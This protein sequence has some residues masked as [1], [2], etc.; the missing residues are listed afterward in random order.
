MILL[1]EENPRDQA[2][3]L[4]ALNTSK[5]INK[6]VIAR[7]GEEALDYLFGTGPYAGRDTAVVPQF[8]LLDLK[9]PRVDGLEVLQRI[10]ADERTKNLPV[11][12][13]TSS[14][15][16]EDLVKSYDLGANSY[17][18][19]P[20]MLEHFLEATRQ[21]GLY[22]L[23]LNQVAKVLIVHDQEVVREGVKKI[24]QEQPG[25]TAFGEASNASE[26]LRLVRE[27]D[28]DVALLNLSLG[29]RGGLEALKQIKQIRPNLPVLILSQHS[30]ELYARRS[31]KA[32]AAGYITKDSPR[33]EL[34]K[35]VNN[36]M[37][38]R[39]Y[40]SAAVAEKLI[41]DIGEGVDR[42]PHEALSDREFEVMRL[43]ASGK[44]VGEIAEILS[45]SDKTI[46]TYRTRLLEKMGMKT[47]AEITRY[48]I[49]NMLVD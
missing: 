31:F 47:N 8:V 22:W 16:D 35:A 14:N 4:R 32:G 37:S 41:V 23:A 17:I 46:S 43:I 49:V 39:R 28:W 29:G 42:L 18:R 26:A 30:E 15:E 6:V 40:V 5:I 10:R 24:L 2:L 34:I 11:V 38:G 7:D 9:L 48:G 36:V 13:F 19:K 33:Q 12:V 21:L 1:V 20:V 44:T 3:V 45:L 27:Q 25:T